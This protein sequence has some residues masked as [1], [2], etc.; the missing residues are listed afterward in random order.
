MLDGNRI[1][2]YKLSS[3]MRRVRLS[4]L[5]SLGSGRKPKL[6]CNE[7]KLTRHGHEYWSEDN[8]G[9]ATDQNREVDSVSDSALPT[10][11]TL[12]DK[13]GSGRLPRA[14]KVKAH[15]SPPLPHK[16]PGKSHTVR[17]LTYSRR[18]ARL[19]RKGEHHRCLMMP[20]RVT[21]ARSLAYPKEA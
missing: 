21:L 16:G 9:S 5:L 20:Q 13:C 8:C 19:G 11:A 1:Y 4:A 10:R 6:K 12:P 14:V 3:D 18:D 17:I 7:R 15:A 2:P